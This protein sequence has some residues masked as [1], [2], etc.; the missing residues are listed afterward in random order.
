VVRGLHGVTIPTQVCTRR[1][2]YRAE[3]TAAGPYELRDGDILERVDRFA[4]ELMLFARRL[5]ASG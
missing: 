5:V 3:P 1:E 2:D 4:E